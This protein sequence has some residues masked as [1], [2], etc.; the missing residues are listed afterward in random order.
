MTQK[1]SGGYKYILHL[2]DHFSTSHV[3]APLV[4][5][6]QAEVNLA[7]YHMFSI[8]GIPVILHTDNGSEFGALDRLLQPLP[9][10]SHIIHGRPWN[11]ILEEKM[12]AMEAI[13]HGDGPAPWHLWLPLIQC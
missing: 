3:L 11:W 2:V 4:Q 13:Y 7:L 10:S 1:P 8:I 9:G 5:K 12:S 6:T